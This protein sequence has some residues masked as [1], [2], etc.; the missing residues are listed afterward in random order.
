[1]IPPINVVE[2]VAY[3]FDISTDDLLGPVRVRKFSKPRQ[4]CYRL[5]R[6]LTN[7]KVVEIAALF[8]K[9]HSTVI[10]GIEAFEFRR[11]Q[12]EML[13]YDTLRNH[14]IESSGH[15]Q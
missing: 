13:I 15:P 4:M 7:I 9:D 6:D 14:L 11:D 8:N 2:Q 12:K 10:K 5:L 1:M 3:Y